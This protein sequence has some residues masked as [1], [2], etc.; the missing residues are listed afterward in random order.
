MSKRKDI[1][2]GIS[3]EG[4]R[5]LEEFGK[6]YGYDCV[7]V[8]KW[9]KR[10]GMPYKE[11]ERDGE[12]V[13]C[14]NSMEE[15]ET[16]LLWF[17]NVAKPKEKYPIDYVPDE[18]LSIKTQ[19]QIH[20]LGYQKKIV[21]KNQE[22][23]KAKIIAEYGEEPLQAV[24]SFAI[25]QGFHPTMAYVWRTRFAFPCREIE[26]AF[27]IQ[28]REKAEEFIRWYKDTRKRRRNYKTGQDDEQ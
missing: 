9:W 4:E 3:V 24:T 6:I 2:V 22:E 5:T 25:E 26:G 18:G 19:G 16:F 23:R 28:S 1:W 11:I 20:Y 14:I 7:W 21:T 15:A 8:K 17:Q 12:L 13:K 27:Y 10:Y